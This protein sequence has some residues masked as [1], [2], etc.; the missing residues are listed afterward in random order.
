VHATVEAEPS[1]ETELSFEQTVPRADAHRRALGEVFVTDSVQTADDEF[2]LA[3]QI[4]RAHSLWFD[5]LAPYHDPLSTAEA[6]RQAAFVVVHRHV[7][8]PH[9][10]PFSLRRFEFHVEDLDAYRDDARS[11][12]EGILRFRLAG[13]DKRDGGVGSLSYQ[14]S[15]TIDGSLAMTV[16]GDIVFLPRTDY[17][18]LRAYQR[19]RRRVENHRPAACPEPI[20]AELVGRLDRRNVVIAEASRSGAADAEVRYPLV[21]DRTHPSFFD[22]DYDHVPGPLIAEA[23][24]EAAIVTAT[25]A[26]AL[27]SPVAAMT[28]CDATFAGFAE[29]EATIDCSAS[30]GA[31]SDEGRVTVQVGLHQFEERIATGEVEVMPFP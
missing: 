14:G 30:V 12:L 5:R 2:L 23:Y 15:L 28:S 24:R 27:T 21:V 6:A 31:V 17:E 13:H 11:P 1:G 18:A 9:G 19:R 3:V 26:G 20:D 10:L 16:G 25:R 7:G 8:L 22:H 4:P 29:F